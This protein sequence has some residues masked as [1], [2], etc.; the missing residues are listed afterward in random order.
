MPAKVHI[1]VAKTCV[2]YFVTPLPYTI[3]YTTRNIEHF[4]KECTL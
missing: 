3:V 1:V 4:R 2:T